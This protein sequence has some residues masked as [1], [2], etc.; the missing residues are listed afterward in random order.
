[1]TGELRDFTVPELLQ[2]ESWYSPVRSPRYRK[3]QSTAYGS[4]AWAWAGAGPGLLLSKYNAEAMEWSI[5]EKVKRQVAGVEKTLM[6]FGG[7]ARWKLGDPEGAAFLAP[8]DRF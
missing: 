4:E 3:Q 5:I 1:E 8:G 2:S 6:R 7:G